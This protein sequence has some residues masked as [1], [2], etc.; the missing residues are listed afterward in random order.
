VSRV[1]RR[2]ILW[3]FFLTAAAVSAHDWSVLA[4][5]NR[6]QYR[7]DSHRGVLTHTEFQ[8]TVYRVLVPYSL[9]PP[10]RF[11]AR[12]MP[13]E[14]AFGRVYAAFYLFALAGLL[15]A[16]YAYL[17]IHFTEEQALVGALVIAATL[18]MG[19]RYYD[20]APYSQLE[21][22]FFALALLLM[23]R[24]R[25][26]LLGLLIA[27]ASLNRETAIFIV[28]LFCVVWPLTKARASIAAA[29]GAVWLAVF[30]GLRWLIGDGQPRYWTLDSIW[31]GNTHEWSQI[32]ISLVAVALLYGAFWLFAVLG[33]ARAPAFVRRSAIIVPPYIATVAAWGVWTEVRL[34]QPLYPIIIPLGLSY[35][36]APRDSAVPGKGALQ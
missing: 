25:H 29:Y 36:F 15:Y 17:R 3:L 34:L 6:R 10:I 26:G 22:T 14:D 35:L 31:L 30:F 1:K 8:P 13:Y 32:A 19:L 23:Y 16:Q 2:L 9:E 28:A 4:G 18:P 7:L 27:I 5:D 33:F 24:R 12:F 21:P 20:F 11:L